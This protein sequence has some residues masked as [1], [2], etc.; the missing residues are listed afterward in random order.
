MSGKYKEFRHLEKIKQGAVFIQKKK[1][2]GLAMKDEKLFVRLNPSETA[3][4]FVVV[5]EWSVGINVSCPI[6]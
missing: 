3:Y 4:V 6:V 1:V 2:L 5:M